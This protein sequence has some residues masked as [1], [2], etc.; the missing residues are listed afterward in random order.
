VV[1]GLVDRP[2]EQRRVPLCWLPGEGNL[3]VVGAA[4]SGTTTTLVALAASARS[5]GAAAAPEVIGLERHAGSLRALIDLPATT[6]AGPAG[7]DRL[8]VLHRLS[9][10]LDART[11]GA[12]AGPPILVLV[13]GWPAFPDDPD[14]WAA[15]EA[16]VRLWVDGPAAGIHLAVASERSA[17]IPAA[18]AAGTTQRWYLRPCDPSELVLAGLGTLGAAPRFVPGRLLVA[19]GGW[20]AQVA[21]P[22]TVLRRLTRSRAPGLKFSETH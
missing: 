7:P 1:V 9:A 5:T 12:E 20:E 8:D 3:L 22:G 14:G 2:N 15:R 4:G 13:D 18:V 19:G 11:S 6:V 21:L 10:S 16:L 17:A